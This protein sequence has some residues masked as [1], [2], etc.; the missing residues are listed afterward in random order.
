MKYNFNTRSDFGKCQFTN[1]TVTF[2]ADR[3]YEEASFFL[4][5]DFPEWEEDCY[6]LIPACAY[7]GNRFKSVERSYPPMYL[8]D[9]VGEKAEPQI[10]CGIPSLGKD[11]KGKLECSVADAA[12]PIIGIFNRKAKNA[13]F[14]FTE[15]QIK[16]KNI[17]Y[18]IV[19]GKITIQFPARREY[20]YRFHLKPDYNPDSGIAV[21]SG[22]VIS[23][24]VLI[25]SY[26]CENIA[27][28]YE[29]FFNV[30]KL[31]LSDPRPENGYTP[32]LWRVMEAH[33][34]DHNYSGKYY[35]NTL[36]ITWQTGW[37]GG[38]MSSYPLYMLG[39]KR[40]KERAIQT[41]DFMTSFISPSGL[42]YSTVYA[43]EEIRDDSQYREIRGNKT[44]SQYAHMQGAHLVRRSGDILIFLIKQLK[45][46]MPVKQKWID[47]ARGVA[48]AMV[49]V[50]KKYGTFGQFIHQ[51]TL[52]ML[53]SQSASGAS[54][55]GGL[56]MAADYFKNDEYME[57]AKAA[58]EFYYQKFV[59]EGITSGGPGDAMTAPD[60]ESSY[61]FV[62]SYVI[63]YELTGE[64]KWLKYSKDAANIFSSW[65]MTYAFK[66][67]SDKEFSIL[68]IN[69]VGS[70]F[71][72]VQNKHSAP[73]ICTFSGDTL[74]RLYKHTGEEKYLELIKDIAYFMPQCI[75]R[76]ER[77]IY[78][79]DHKHGDP[80]GRLPAGYICERVNTSDWEYDFSVGGVFNVSCWCETS[81]ALT[82]LELMDKPE[83]K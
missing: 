59:T 53:Y 73:G 15:Q 41:L 3:D 21:E 68:G 82:F 57:V 48:N 11:G 32:E 7:N 70:V 71:A 51:D 78:D 81:V 67:P 24:K 38:G 52:E 39:D 77:P 12:S 14:L 61:A 29:I 64:E 19:N 23:T 40:S 36:W 13:F 5:I 63:L 44:R 17:G 55:I 27:G 22:E 28:F 79:W 37:T 31:L 46:P 35:G 49:Q 34:N 74:Y 50:F 6:V 45:S 72:N 66:F 9:E 62:E 25:R 4:D 69:T 16:D 56:A 60:S 47:A 20:A 76:D 10:M 54:V 8:A 43:G 33:F 58:G 65:V 2:R 18:S 83:M 42:I 80:K 1:D 75:S 30:R 26:P